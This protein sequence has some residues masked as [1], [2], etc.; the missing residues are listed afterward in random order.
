[1]NVSVILPSLNPDEKLI[2]VVKGLIDKGFTDIIIVNDG[3]DNE[4]LKP[5]V[6][7]AAYPQVTVLR[8]EINRG[9]GR[10]LKT[11][12]EYLLKNRPDIDGAVTVD[13]DNQHTPE[14]ILA[15][16]QRMAESGDSVVLG[17]R[18]FSRG[19]VP[20]KSYYGNTITRL[21]FKAVCGINISD[22]QTGL[23]AIP[24]K[25]FELMTKIEG[26]RFEYETEMLLRLQSK[27]IRMLE[28]PI[29]TVYIDDNQ[30]SH[31][32][33]FRDSVMI[34]RMILRY[35]VGAFA[36]FLIDYGV[37][38]VLVLLIGAEA[39][40]LMRLAC[41]YVPARLLSS[42]F[43]YTFNRKAVFRT[44]SPLGKTLRRYYTLW[45]CQLIVSLGLE[46][47]LSRLLGA[48]PAG[49]ILIKIPLELG[50]FIASYQVQQRWV[51]RG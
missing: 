5:F 14:D 20:F 42:V 50:I 2:K 43:N 31:F 18:D 39:P 22:T 8:H 12:F 41:A 38:S 49:E 33:P 3:S 11:A 35:I 29:Q 44:D 51:F 9:K 45:F 15:V 4:H 17:A 7:A 46:Y 25:Y 23:R 48:A 36:S 6:E 13:G 10:A 16:S 47:A 21:I 27:R 37:F 32:K 1:M 26:E 40:R 30:T 34:Y 24:L 19:N 28:V